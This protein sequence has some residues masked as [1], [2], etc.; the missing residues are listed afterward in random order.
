MNSKKN[1]ALL[2]VYLI[3][4]EDELKRETVMK[5]LRSRLE[6]M[7]DLSFNS[8]S[9]SCTDCSVEDVITAC[10]T[11]PFASSVR[12]VEVHDTEK[13]KKADSEALAQ[14]LERPCSTT[15]LALVGQKV[16][17]RSKLYKAVVSLDK[18]AFIDCAPFARKDMN[19]VVRSMAVGHGI[20]FTEGAASALIDLVGTNTVG[21]DAELKKLALSHRGSDPVN[22][23]EV[24]SMVARTAEIKPWEFLDALSA[25]NAQRCVYLF[26]RME[27]V[28]SLGLL[29][30]CTSR[31]RDILTTK[32]LLRRGEQGRLA[33]V[34]NRRDWQVKKYIQWAKLSSFK[35]L[36]DCLSRARDAEQDMKSGKDQE[37]VFIDWVLKFCQKG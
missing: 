21:L 6:K 31:I 34:L 12:L 7:G 5:R 25:R 10:N 29:V 33:N 15:V 24:L 4:G 8:E 20:T 22:E 23:N 35:D 27:S 16:D 32:T 26:N 14:Y 3:A 2:P 9:F 28:S 18:T 13:L 17:K 11:L 19:K 1:N 30:M 37:Q 36:I